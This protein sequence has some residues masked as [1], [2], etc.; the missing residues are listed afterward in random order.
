MLG[1]I[2]SIVLPLTSFANNE[3]FFTETIDDTTSIFSINNNGDN[4]RELVKN[5]YHPQLMPN[6]KM[7]AFI[8]K[9]PNGSKKLEIISNEGV[10]LHKAKSKI[11]L[12][13]NGQELRQNVCSFSWSPDSKL[14]AFTS[15][16]YRDYSYYRKLFLE[17]Y[18]LELKETKKLCE[19]E[20][21]DLDEASMSNIQWIENGKKII[22]PLPISKKGK[23]FYVF[24]IE[25]R[26]KELVV[27]EES[28][29][30]V[31]GGSEI[32]YMTRNK[33]E[34][35]FWSIDLLNKK[36]EL[37]YKTDESLINIQKLIPSSKIINKRLIITA[38]APSSQPVYILD[39]GSKKLKKFTIEDHLINFPELSTQGDKIV[40]Y[41][42]EN[43]DLNKNS[44]NFGLYT[45]D[46]NVQKITLLKKINIATMDEFFGYNFMYGNN[47][48]LCW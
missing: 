46:M 15:F 22:L 34:Y 3:I 23:G 27:E 36:K 10:V 13:M 18:D 31:W 1:F 12:K 7:I 24:D 35:S 17:V 20:V 25:K 9:H 4:L 2:L 33:N 21:D 44:N 14:I 11:K 40:F 47:V 16:F 37:I 5:A 43:E 45:Y 29:I 38:L 41:G 42:I 8:K 26:E 6:G 28:I 48:Y 39:I 19:M 30:K 32:V